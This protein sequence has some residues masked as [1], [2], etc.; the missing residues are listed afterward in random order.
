MTKVSASQKAL[1][2]IIK[3]E[4]KPRPRWLFSVKNILLWIFGIMSMIVGALFVSV[5]IFTMMNSDMDLHREIY[6]YAISYITLCTVLVWFVLF[7]VFVMLC[8]VSVRHTKRGYVYPLRVVVFVHIGAS[9]LFGMVLYVTGIGYY[10]DDALGSHMRYYYGVEKRRAASFHVPDKG[11][12][13]GRIVQ[14]NDQ[15]LEIVSPQ[16]DQWIVT[17]ANISPQKQEYLRDNEYAVF[18][19]TVN[20]RNIFIACD[21][22]MRNLSGVRFDRVVRSQH[23][24]IMARHMEQQEKVMQLI[25][26]LH[27]GGMDPCANGLHWHMR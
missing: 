15:A 27:S 24:A 6:G 12:V 5:I 23:D 7:G 1:E 16:G 25:R 22:K 20:D 3:G 17:I 9:I 26:E 19:G 11:F 4:V 14:R 13:M 18:L 2:K 8:D 10:V 21:V